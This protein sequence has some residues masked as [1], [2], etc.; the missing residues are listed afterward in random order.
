MASDLGYVTLDA[1]PLD[2]RKG[3]L[4]CLGG[5]SA[6]GSGGGVEAAAAAAAPGADAPYAAVAA[7][8]SRQNSGSDLFEGSAWRPD[9]ARVGDFS[10]LNTPNNPSSDPVAVPSPLLPLPP[11]QPG[12]WTVFA[13]RV[14]AAGAASVRMHE[15]YLS[16]GPATSV[17]FAVGQ[18]CDAT[19]SSESPG[20]TS[21]PGGHASDAIDAPPQ[22]IC[23]AP[24]LGLASGL[25]GRDAPFGCQP[26]PSAPSKQP[27]TITHPEDDSAASKLPKEEMEA[28]CAAAAEKEGPI[29]GV[30]LPPL[31]LRAG[32]V[33][34]ITSFS[35]NCSHMLNCKVVGL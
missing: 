16:L 32:T 12:E 28:M 5:G 10:T 11:L 6:L 23:G 17:S 27:E 9:S 13:A 31:H 35:L 18:L 14:H 1:H 3:W 15:V 34:Q 8:S 19:P 26:F 29:L 4:S 24:A 2:S 30:G 22:I 20:T 33:L 7:A 21:T 25:V